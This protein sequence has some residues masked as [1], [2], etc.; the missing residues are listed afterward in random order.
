[1]QRY[2]H[3]VWKVQVLRTETKDE[4]PWLRSECT[5]IITRLN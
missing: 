3:F 1:M 5:K 2:E 4:R